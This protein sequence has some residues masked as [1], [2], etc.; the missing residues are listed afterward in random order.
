MS[1]NIVGTD[2]LSDC[3]QVTN[4]FVPD[5][6]TYLRKCVKEFS[7]FISKDGSNLMCQLVFKE[8]FLSDGASIPTC[9][10]SIINKPWDNKYILP[11][12]VHDFG[13]SLRQFSRKKIDEILYDTLRQ[14]GMGYTDCLLVYG[15]VR[16]GGGKAW[17]KETPMSVAKALMVTDFI[18]KDI[19]K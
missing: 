7:I 8:G 4:I 1:W 5:N 15:A 13:Y 6:G 12:L 2:Y 18:T 10:Q 9:V 11:Y 17:H 19:S 3:F 16:L 14:A